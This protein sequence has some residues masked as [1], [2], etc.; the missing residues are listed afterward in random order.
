MENLWVYLLLFVIALAVLLY[1]VGRTCTSI[2]RSEIEVVDDEHFADMFDWALDNGVWGVYP[3][4]TYDEL[5]RSLNE[6]YTLTL[7]PEPSSKA[8]IAD[9]LLTQ[10]ERI[11]LLLGYLYEADSAGLAAYIYSV[12]GDFE[13]QS[14]K[15]VLPLTRGVYR[16]AFLQRLGGLIQLICPALKKGMQVLSKVSANLPATKP[17]ASASFNFRSSR[18]A[19]AKRLSKYFPSLSADELAAASSRLAQIE[20]FADNIQGEGPFKVFRK[21]DL[22]ALV[23]SAFGEYGTPEEYAELITG[24]IKSL[25]SEMHVHLDLLKEL[26]TPAN[27]AR[28]MAGLRALK[29]H[30]SSLIVKL[31]ELGQFLQYPEFLSTHGSAEGSAIRYA[32]P[33]PVHPITKIGASSVRKVLVPPKSFPTTSMPAPAPAPASAPASKFDIEGWY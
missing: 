32:P 5:R 33:Q 25:P 12:Q 18:I 14:M 31:S 21:L 16:D 26:T 1:S 29:P 7:M 20:L 8:V 30:V 13:R 22:A 11:P 28:L 15:K 27:S 10:L 19:H 4:K 2:A 17:A 23:L 3:M 24:M 9:A 6:I